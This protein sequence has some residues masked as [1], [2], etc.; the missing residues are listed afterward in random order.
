MKN[1][2]NDENMIRC[3]TIIV[4]NSGVG[5][6]AII[7]RYINKFDP[8]SKATIGASFTNKLEIVNDKQ[9]LFEIWDTAGQERFRSVNSIFYQDAYICILVYDITNQKSFQDL[10][11]YWHD[12]VLE[13]TSKDIIFHIVG[14]KMDLL[15]KEVVEKDEVEEFGKTIGAEI[16][17]TSAK[18]ENNSYISLLFQ[19]L[20]EKFVNSDFYINNESKLKNKKTNKIKLDDDSNKEKK[21]K[22]RKKCC[23]DK[24]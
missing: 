1:K 4:G 24:N 2:K 9:I 20:A 16:S 5:K 15:E 7:S 11:E 22:K 3:K 13:Q 17:Y 18:E 23:R 12:S 8:N 19:K 21:E 6:T 10:K 14:N